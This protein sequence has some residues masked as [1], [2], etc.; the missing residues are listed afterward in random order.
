MNAPGALL[1]SRS[2]EPLMSIWFGNFY[3]PAYD[4]RAFVRRM[5]V[6]LR[7][8]GFNSVE[9]D[10]KA[11]EDF[12][13]RFAGGAAS[14][15]VAQQE[16]MMRTL[17]E[18]GLAY[19]FLALYLNGDNLY[20]DIRFSPPIWGESVT[21]PDGS[22]GRW[23]K[24]WSDAAQESMVEHVSGLMRLYGERSARLQTESG[25]R[26]PLCS[27]WDPIVAPSFDAEGRKRYQA[28]LQNRYGNIDAFN[29]AY[30][31]SAADFSSLQPQDYWFTARFG[32]NACYTLEDLRHKTPAFRMWCD[33]ML[34]RADELTAY[35]AA[36]DR[37]L[38]ALNPRLYLMPCLAQ[39]SFFLNVDASKIT[40]IGFSDLW[41]TAMRGLDPFRIAPHVDMAHFFAVPVTMQG[42]ANA[43]V[44]S[45]QHAII[46]ALNPGRPFLGGV[47]WGRFLYNDVYA[48]VSPAEVVGSIVAS[49]ASGI[50]AYGCCG[51]DDG[52]LLHRMD[53][54]FTESL[55]VGNEWAKAV[56][57][58][59]G[60]RKCDRVAL[61]FP[62]AMSL[63]EPLRVEGAEARR[64]DLLGL[65]TCCCDMGYAPDVI[66]PETMLKHGLSDYQLLLLPA[67]D[68]Y[69]MLP[70]PEIEETLRAFVRQGGTVLHGACDLLA[71]SAFGVE[72]L[73]GDTDCYDYHGE[74]GLLLR[75]EQCAY[76]GE[77]LAVWRFTGKGC[78]TQRTFGQGRIISFGF[79]PGYQYAARTAPHVPRTQGNAALY[80]LSFMEPSPLCDALL[81]CLPRREKAQKGVERA[82][83]EQGEVVVN[84]TSHPVCLDTAGRRCSFQYNVDGRTLVGHSAAVIWTR[85]E[86]KP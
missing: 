19:Y 40:G 45:A 8:M 70:N 41:D 2:G 66:G 21:A 52:G 38:H 77:S 86:D 62:S 63:L 11:W 35:F 53:E 29:R 24:Y 84:H 75:A 42:D 44:V 4:D 34:W 22:C 50:A 36:M 20:P 12:A 32:E 16:Y 72:P 31:T 18:A 3:Q 33:N 69:D 37:R 65:Y 58:R 78:I 61:L 1:E 67:N 82:R 23:Y 10:S 48:F 68:C 74:G 7:Q 15:Y 9:L 51:M 28:W 76:D 71:Q 43:Y 17:P 80:P 13:A 59:L 6:L 39:W 56:I 54:G 25:E 46:R 60:A 64:L 85:E 5:A 73:D 57:P 27:M 83:F 14:P 79:L 81:S 55:G 30:Q 47:Y 49:G 26:V